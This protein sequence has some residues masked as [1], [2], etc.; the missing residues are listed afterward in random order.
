[1]SV[2]KFVTE[3]NK[4]FAVVLRGNQAKIAYFEPGKP[5]R[6]IDVNSFKTLVANRPKSAAFDSEDTGK[7]WLNHP[8]RREYKEVVFAPG[9]TTPPYVL[10]LWRG[11]ATEPRQG[12]VTPFLELVDALCGGDRVLVNYILAWCADLIQNPGAK[13]GTALVFLGE[14]GTGKSTFV[15]ILEAMVGRAYCLTVPSARMI[16]RNFN[17]QLEAKLLVVLEEGSFKAHEMAV[18]KDIITRD[19]MLCEPKGVDPFEVDNMIRVIV[20]TNQSHAIHAQGNERRFVAIPVSNR[21][22]EDTAFF[23]RLM[24]WFNADGKS[25]VLHFLKNYDL[26]GINLRV[27][28]RTEALLN[29]K[30]E[31]LDLFNRAIFN[32]LKEDEIDA[33]TSWQGAHAKEKIRAAINKY[34]RKGEIEI[35]PASLGRKLRELFPDL[36][37]V[38]KSGADRQREIIFPPLA[39]ARRLF[40]RRLGQPIGWEAGEVS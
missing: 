16:V 38:R 13:C 17:S 15:R 25:A 33:G 32:M 39:E 36:R 29:Q 22:R 9:V 7:A 14:Q 21:Y 26:S 2:P 11:F 4:E 37:E 34:V 20:D 6:F 19:R 5:V 23:Q 10:N 30:L 27:V 24:E 12:D 40:E 3:L 35:T 28:P 8:M 1:M 31:S 18:L